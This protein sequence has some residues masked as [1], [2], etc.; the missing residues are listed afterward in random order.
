MATNGRQSFTLLLAFGAMIFGM[1][2]AGGFDL[3]PVGFAQSGGEPVRLAESNGPAALPSFA[4]LAQAVSPAVVS[5]QAVKIER[6]GAS[7]RRGQDPFE[8]F[9][10]PR[11][12]SP[13]PEAPEQDERRDSS[14][15]GFVISAD[16]L[17]V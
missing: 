11:R 15:S 3:T 5:I 8:F 10:G 9:F 6:G 16:G 4:D 7:P 14:G 2:L 1:V 13:N 17:I 12:R